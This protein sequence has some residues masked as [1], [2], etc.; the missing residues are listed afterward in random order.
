MLLGAGGSVSRE[1]RGEIHGLG[2]TLEGQRGRPISGSRVKRT[3]GQLSSCWRRE[4]MI[5]AEVLY[6]VRNAGRN[7]EKKELF[8]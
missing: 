8:T 1:L 7:G 5:W 3:N 6:R 2:E 4:Q